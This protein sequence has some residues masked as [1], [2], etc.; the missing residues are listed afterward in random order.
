MKTLTLALALAFTFSPSA[1]ANNSCRNIYAKAFE[2]QIKQQE[3]LP[4][5]GATNYSLS[6]AAAFSTYDLKTEGSK[7][8]RQFT[9][10]MQKEISQDITQKEI[11][12]IVDQGIESGLFCRNYPK[13]DS[14]HEIKE[15]VQNVL[16]INYGYQN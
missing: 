13:I 1:K 16:T 6:L 15:H 12:D 4:N 8:L 2:K 11:A 3:I 9:K 5:T 10:K 14:P 7:S